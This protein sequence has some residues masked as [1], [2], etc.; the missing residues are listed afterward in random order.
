MEGA[1]PFSGY[2]FALNNYRLMDKDWENHYFVSG[3]FGKS[4]S[5]VF[6][7]VARSFSL[8]RPPIQT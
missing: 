7:N 5:L 2:P 8:A 3:V 1:S 6:Y 4:Q